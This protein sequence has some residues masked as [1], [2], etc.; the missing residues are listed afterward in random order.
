MQERQLKIKIKD[1][2]LI[3]GEFSIKS[4]DDFKPIFKELKKKYGWF[5]FMGF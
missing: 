5:M 1:N 2:G 4:F 3:L